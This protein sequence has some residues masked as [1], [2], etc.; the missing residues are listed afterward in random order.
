MPASEAVPQ[1]SPSKRQKG[2]GPAEVS[3]RLRFTKLSEN[4]FAPSRGS[5][6]A[7]GYDLYSAYDCV[8]P[9]M[10]KAVVKTDIQIA[11][12]SGCYGR[13]APRS[14]LAAKHFID[15][16][17]G[18]IDEDYRGNVGV[19]LFNFGKETFEVKKGDRIAQLICERIYYP[20]LEEVEALDDTERGEGGFGSTG[21]N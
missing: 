7:A 10:E 4:A 8:I 3:A 18:V 9:P 21:K 12:P 5:A 16:G 19:V 17:A 6:R 13:V 15:V 2:S 20:E 11:L 14:G 1:P